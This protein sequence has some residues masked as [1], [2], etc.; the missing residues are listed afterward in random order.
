MTNRNGLK[1]SLLACVLAISAAATVR[2]AD[3]VP[4]PLAESRVRPKEFGV[5]DDTITVIPATA[6][7]GVV[8]INPD[9]SVSCLGCVIQ[10]EYWAPFELPS[11]AVIDSIGVNNA[12]DTNAIMGVAL[13]QRMGNAVKTM[14]AGF[15]FPAHGWDTDYSGPLDIQVPYN[16]GNEWVLQVEQAANPSG[17]PEYFAWVEIHWHRTVGPAPT[18]PTFNDV[19]TS[20][21]AFQYIEQL[22]RSGITGGCGAGNYCPDAPLTRRQMAIFL[23]KALG[24]HWPN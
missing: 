24:L 18:F 1:R 4:W 5:Q 23:A 13:W 15:S 16:F 19:P 21:F 7:V 17:T 22:A 10:L 20:D 2:A 8:D 6:F 14:Q 11:G 9:L 3:T 12:T